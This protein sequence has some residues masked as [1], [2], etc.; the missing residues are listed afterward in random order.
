MVLQGMGRSGSRDP[1]NAA[2]RHCRDL[3]FDFD[4]LAILS[5]ALTDSPLLYEKTHARPLAKVQGLL[6]LQ[7]MGL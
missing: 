7:T 2:Y 1:P 4:K 5:R 3:L 6:N